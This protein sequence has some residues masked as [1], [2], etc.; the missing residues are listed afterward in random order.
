M[1][2]LI[3]NGR[4]V[5]VDAPDDTRFCGSSASTCS[6]PARS[7]AAAAGFAVRARSISTASP[8]DPAR[9][10]SRT[11]A[12]ADHDD[13]GPERRTA[14]IRCRRPGSPSRFRNA[15]IA[16]PA[17]SWPAAALRGEESQPN[18]RR[19]RRRYERQ[20]LPLHDLLAHREGDRARAEEDLRAMNEP[21]PLGGAHDPP[22]QDPIRRRVDSAAAR[23]SSPAVSPG[24]MFGFAGLAAGRRARR[25]G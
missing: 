17:R 6:S 8:S 24:S 1:P 11:A 22:R 10:R 25:D 15:A 14:I 3:V 4:Q 12:D 23:S 13:R 21:S 5:A 2:K 19:D 18:A 16:S 9:R 7:S 20:S